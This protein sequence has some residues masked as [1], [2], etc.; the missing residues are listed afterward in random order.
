MNRE[1]YLVKSY[2]DNI[3]G[4]KVGLIK[5]LELCQKYG[6]GVIVVPM[7]Q[8]IDH[9]MLTTVLGEEKS[10]K[11]I[12]NR[13]LPIENG[14]TVGLCS[15]NTL[16]NHTHFSVYLALWGSNDIIQA[17]E[18]T[19]HNREAVILVTWIPEDSKD[20]LLHNTVTVIYDD[21]KG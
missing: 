18:K 21:K 13:T 5:F 17:I 2:G 12:K 19:C 10:K 1:R 20:W 9:T 11:L 3:E 16:K 4:T 6:S 7:L 15:A 8:N 14:K